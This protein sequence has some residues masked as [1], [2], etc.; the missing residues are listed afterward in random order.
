MFLWLCIYNKI[1]TI[2]NLAKMRELADVICLFCGDNESVQ[3]LMFDC[4]VASHV[5]SFV[6]ECFHIDTITSFDDVIAFL[7]SEKKNSVINMVISAS[8]W[9]S[10]FFLKL[11]A[12]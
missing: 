3:H 8:F 9:S 4:V 2:D 1:L 12:C 11:E 5:W 6:S 7:H 10:F